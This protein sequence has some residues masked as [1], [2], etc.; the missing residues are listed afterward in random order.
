VKSE[1]RSFIN[2]LFLILFEKLKIDSGLENKYL[3]FFAKLKFGSLLTVIWFMSEKSIEDSSK[4][5]CIA[6]LGKPAQCFCL[7]NLSSSKAQII[8]PSFNK[9]AEESP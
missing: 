2:D 7:V 4:Q 5:A 8:L 6:F 1:D 9:H 3:T